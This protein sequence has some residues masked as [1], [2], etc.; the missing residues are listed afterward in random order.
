MR[1]MLFALATLSTAACTT[2][3]PGDIKGGYVHVTSTGTGTV[4]V[5]ACLDPSLLLFCEGKEIN[6][7][8]THDGASTAM[9]YSGIFQPDHSASVPMGNHDA[10]F[11]VSDGTNHAVIALPPEL[12]LIA[13]PEDL[14]TRADVLHVTWTA[15][16]G[17]MDWR[18]S[19]ACPAVNGGVLVGEGYVA[20]LP[21]TGAAD[22]PV[23][24]IAAMI[25]QSPSPITGTCDAT[26]TVERLRDGQIDPAF[27]AIEATGIS[28]RQFSFELKR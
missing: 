17:A 23:E 19:Y 16:G 7:A 22:L 20:A 8:V 21:D 11:D 3:D 1:T 15:A 6:L 13:P 10:M 14:R 9:P 25:D 4:D 27:H 18:V 5:R 24:T 26:I 12:D 2:F 28:M